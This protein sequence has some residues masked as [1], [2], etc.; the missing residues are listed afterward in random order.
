MERKQLEQIRTSLARDRPLGQIDW[1]KTAA[2]KL[3]M[4]HTLRS[5]GRPKKKK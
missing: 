4:E 2:R 1:V 3:G 5:R